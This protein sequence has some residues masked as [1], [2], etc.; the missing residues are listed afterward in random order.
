[1]SAKVHIM[2]FRLTNFTRDLH[3]LRFCFSENNFIGIFVTACKLWDC[4][5]VWLMS[6]SRGLHVNY[7]RVVPI[8][9]VKSKNNNRTVYRDINKNLKIESISIEGIQYEFSS[10]D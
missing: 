5:N 4:V 8:Y 7:F 10:K 9:Q 1:M 3:A 2:N 6:F